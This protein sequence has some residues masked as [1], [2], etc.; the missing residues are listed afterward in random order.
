MIAVVIILLLLLFSGWMLLYKHFKALRSANISLVKGE[1]REAS[2]LF[3]LGE[4]KEK[5]RKLEDKL[6]KVQYELYYEKQKE[7]HR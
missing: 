7:G 4:I 5:N 3:E 6:R 1:Q 2:L